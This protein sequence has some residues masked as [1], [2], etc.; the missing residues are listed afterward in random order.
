MIKIISSILT[1]LILAAQPVF[2]LTPLPRGEMSN[3]EVAEARAKLGPLNS[4]QRFSVVNNLLEAAEALLFLS[5]WEK[6]STAEKPAV[7]A[8]SK[9]APIVAAVPEKTV[10]EK[11]SLDEAAGGGDVFSDTS[12]ALT[13]MPVPQPALT[14]AESKLEVKSEIK[15]DAANP[16]IAYLR[17]FIDRRLLCINPLTENPVALYIAF[18]QLRL[19]DQATFVA[20]VQRLYNRF[21]QLRSRPQK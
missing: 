9:P 15:P 6:C 19:D 5:K 16:S 2:A 17:N 12:S 13:E 18:T 3:R 21:Q 8:K 4:E 20:A 11:V 10:P 7:E 1:S 14:K